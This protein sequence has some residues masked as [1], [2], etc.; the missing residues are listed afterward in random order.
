MTERV[1]RKLNLSRTLLLSAAGLTDVA[2]PV[3]FAVIQANQ[4]QTQL[5]PQNTPGS[6]L[7]YEVASIKENKSGSDKQGIFLPPSGL[8]A[9]NVA[10]RVLIRVA[11]GVQDNQISEEPKWVNSEN[12]D[13]E[14]K[15]DSSVADALRKLSE[16]QRKLERQRMLQAL[17]ADRF[18]LTLHRESK[19]LPVY[20]LVLGKRRLKLQK[21]NYESYPNGEPDYV[22]ILRRGS[23]TAQALSMERLAGALSH[24]LGR[25]VVDK[26]GLK[27]TYHFT[28]QWTPDESE[29]FKE[30]TENG[31]PGIAP[32]PDSSAPSVF[33]A[34][35]EQLGLKLDSR[36]APMDVLVIDHVERPS[37]N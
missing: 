20:A 23:I 5:Q 32:E 2:S 1:A 33:T 30:I 14:A 4:N 21:T 28:I 35:Q 37:E 29:P 31:V 24:L 26:T 10:L 25:K 11:Y 3:M 19:E 18:K 6:A 16:G 27:G 15:M 8:K 13:V 36:K 17:L 34:V 22:A 9:T 12:Y 7:Q